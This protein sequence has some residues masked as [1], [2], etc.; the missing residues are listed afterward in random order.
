MTRKALL[1]MSMQIVFG[2]FAYIFHITLALPDYFNYGEK[3]SSLTK[4]YKMVK[5]GM[6]FV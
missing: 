4:K 6:R 5:K 1:I 2:I 3:K